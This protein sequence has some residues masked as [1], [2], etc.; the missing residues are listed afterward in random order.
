MITPLPAPPTRADPANFADRADEFLSQ[1]PLFVTETN[2]VALDLTNKT[3]AAEGYRDAAQLSQ[4][5]ADQSALA[6]AA[7]ATAPLWISGT[8]YALGATVYSPTSALIYR[9]ITASSVSTVNPASDTTNWSQISTGWPVV[10]ESTATAVTAVAFRH[11]IM[12]NAALCTVTLPVN[13]RINDVVFVTFTNGRIDN[14]IARNGQNIMALAENM[15]VN[16][17]GTVQ[18]FYVSATIGW[19]IV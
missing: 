3:I 11:V 5:L 15:D 17:S 14:V 8:T 9:K 13:P 10:L 16:I 2:D 12:T 6:A 18:L 1:L 4:T 19:R 7:S